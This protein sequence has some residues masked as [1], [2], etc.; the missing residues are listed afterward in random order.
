MA[1]RN[2]RTIASL[3]KAIYHG[4]SVLPL[5]EQAKQAS[6][7]LKPVHIISALQ[8]YAL[9]DLYV[10]FAKYA[11]YT[12]LCT[13]ESSIGFLVTLFNDDIGRW[14]EENPT[15]VSSFRIIDQNAH[16]DIVENYTNNGY[17]VGFV[18]NQQALMKISYFDLLNMTG[19]CADAIRQSYN[20][21]ARP[22][23]TPIGCLKIASKAN[24]RSQPGPNGRVLG[25]SIPNPDVF[26]NYYA[27]HGDINSTVSNCD[28]NG[29][30]CQVTDVWYQVASLGYGKEGYEMWIRESSDGV[31]RLTDISSNCQTNT[32]MQQ[33]DTPVS[34]DTSPVFYI[35]EENF[36]GFTND[37]D[38]LVF[39]LAAES[40]YDLQAARDIAYVFRARMMSDKFPDDLFQVMRQYGPL[41]NDRIYAWSSWGNL[42]L[43]NDFNNNLSPAQQA[44]V[45]QI[46]SE[47]VASLKR[48]PQGGLGTLAFPVSNPAIEHAVY[49]AGDI[50]YQSQVE[51]DAYNIGSKLLPEEIVRRFRQSSLFPNALSFNQL[52]AIYVD[53]TLSVNSAPAGLTTVFYS[54]FYLDLS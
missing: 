7:W 32:L 51:I 45:A 33:L 37:D 12:E 8:S 13:L 39:I 43:V 10:N 17:L 15:A 22:A 21:S 53:H 28:V 42:T 54:D 46:R 34:T 23:P 25:G 27:V 14:D 30:N 26:Y 24:V 18:D 3:E 5:L 19:G 31:Q 16:P 9:H 49:T 29:N 44:V 38:I 11:Q 52:R 41:G 4:D 36:G 1:N 50:L 20:L 6:F 35:E 40:A 48:L 2:T 47:I